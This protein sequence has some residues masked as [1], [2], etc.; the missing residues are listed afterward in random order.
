MEN[1]VKATGGQGG[2]ATGRSHFRVSKRKARQKIVLVGS[3]DKKTSALANIFPMLDGWRS[4]QKWVV[5]TG[6]LGGTYAIALSFVFLAYAFRPAIETAYR[7]VRAH[8]AWRAINNS[9]TVEITNY[10]TVNEVF[11]GRGKWDSARIITVLMA[12]CSLATWGLELEL[13][14]AYIDDGPVDLLN[15]PPPVVL[16][17]VAGN[18]SADTWQVMLHLLSVNWLDVLCP[19]R[20]RVYSCLWFSCTTVSWRFWGSA[21]SQLY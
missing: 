4:D 10:S 16:R 1:Q 20:P 7:R 18:K 13:G 5:D 2:Q 17:P 6:N 11:R 9:Q 15:R 14:L 12:A 3:G 8:R 21:S 19:W